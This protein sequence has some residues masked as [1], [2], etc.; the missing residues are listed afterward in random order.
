VSATTQSSSLEAPHEP[1]PDQA[2]EPVSTDGRS[3]RWDDHRAARR[4]AL[5]N[6]TRKAVHRKGS[7]VS[8]EEIAAFAGT[9]KSIIYRYFE[10][11]VGLQIAVG[12]QVVAEI[13]DALDQALHSAESL[14]DGIAA[15][16]DTYLAMIEHSPN[17]YYFVTRTGS[18]I[19]SDAG[20][21]ITG[22]G[23]PPLTTFI[24]E[25]DELMRVPAVRELGLDEVAASAWATGQ[26]SFVRGTGEWWL[27]R[28]GQPGIPDRDALAEQITT[29]LWEG[30][31]AASRTA[32]RPKST[33]KES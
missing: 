14:R 20:P 26:S 17:V 22:D 11:K 18:I 7:D 3:T 25:I 31:T 28:R 24:D 15:M 13:R 9:S 1:T 30:V 32:S 33:A 10:D 29:W 23:R 21:R 27:A 19:G 12:A 6:A 2:A 16:V 8:M 4:A 5:V